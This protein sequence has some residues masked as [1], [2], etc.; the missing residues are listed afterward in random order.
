VNLCRSCVI[1]EH[2]VKSSFFGEWVIIIAVTCL[3]A[4]RQTQL[5]RHDSYLGFYTE[6][7]KSLLDAKRKAANAN[8]IDANKD[9]GW[10]C[11][12]EETFVMR[13]ERRTSVMQLL[14]G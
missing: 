8:I 4:I 6:L 3:L 1:S 12:S 11:S 2:F 10:C 7:R 9:G 13:V 5:R 14:V